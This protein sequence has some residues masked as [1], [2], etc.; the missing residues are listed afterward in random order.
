[1]ISH[2]LRVKDA[3]N[4][5]EDILESQKDSQDEEIKGEVNQLEISYIKNP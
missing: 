3:Y 4:K 5:T 1:M 2:L